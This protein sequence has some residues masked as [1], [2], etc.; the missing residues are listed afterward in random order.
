MVETLDEILR[1]ALEYHGS[2]IF[3]VPGSQIMTKSSGKMI[4]VTQDKALPADIA[5]LVD[6]AYEL[7]KRDRE[8][9]QIE[10]DDDFSFAVRDLSQYLP[11][12]RFP[13]YDLPYGCVRH[14]GPKGLQHPGRSHAPCG[15]PQRHDPGDRSCRQ[16]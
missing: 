16:R 13:G 1:K 2:D 14:P 6:R 15:K 3:V 9:L 5:V 10:G 11:S 4:P 8:T 7:A 12:A